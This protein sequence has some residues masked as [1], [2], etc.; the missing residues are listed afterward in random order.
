MLKICNK[1][2]LNLGDIVYAFAPGFDLPEEKRARVVLMRGDK[3]WELLLPAADYEA[4][5]RA[6]ENQQQLPPP[7][8]DLNSRQL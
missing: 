3:V 8:P 6:I 2:L 4:V 1:M 7:D 5:L